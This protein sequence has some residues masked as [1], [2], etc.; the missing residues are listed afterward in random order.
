MKTYVGETMTQDPPHEQDCGCNTCIERPFQERITQLEAENA[1]WGK[2]VGDH[3]QR[4]GELLQ[5]KG[6]LEA[7]V[8]SERTISA[9]VAEQ[10]DSLL[11]QLNSEREKA[12]ALRA[13]LREAGKDVER[14]KG[15]I[16]AREAIAR[17]QWQRK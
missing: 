9:G 3:R 17:R 11:K 13:A 5:Q 14:L 1:E 7:E 15:A 16:A 8:D 2:V 12:N 6:K 4:I 10:R